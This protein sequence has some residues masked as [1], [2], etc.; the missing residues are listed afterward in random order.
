MAKQSD[1]NDSVSGSTGL[2]AFESKLLN[3]FALMLVQERQQAEQ[4][5]LLS[6][7][8]FT[9]REIATLIGTTPNTVS[10]TLSQHKRERRSRAAK[11]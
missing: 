3:L 7:A 5:N 11:K 6:R 2:T 8:G 1:A 10:V 9:S 4:I